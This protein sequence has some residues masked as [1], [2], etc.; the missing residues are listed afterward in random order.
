M[1]HT[2]EHAVDLSSGA[3][4]AV[5]LQGA[6]QGDT[7]TIHQTLAE[8][9]EA[10]AELIEHEAVTAPTEEPKVNLEGLQEVV[11]DKGYH[12]GGVLRDLHGVDCRSYTFR[13]RSGVDGTGKA[14]TRSGNRCTPTDGG[15]EGHVASDCRRSAV[16]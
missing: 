1:A 5:T 6:D 9:G 7:T 15:F 14:N 3:L 2:A 4:L 16:N 12:S 8:A 11:G 10:V 13:S